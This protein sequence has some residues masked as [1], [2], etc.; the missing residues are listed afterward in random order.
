MGGL[1]DEDAGDEDAA[2]FDEGNIE[3]DTGKSRKERGE[4]LRLMM[5]A[6]GNLSVS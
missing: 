4:E 6:D 5:E 1:S 3:T 2:M